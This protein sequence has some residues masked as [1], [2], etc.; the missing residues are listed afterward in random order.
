MLNGYMRRS[1]L[2][3]L[4]LLLS[5][6]LTLAQESKVRF[7]SLVLT[8]EKS[9]WRVDSP[10]G[11]DSRSLHHGDL[12]TTIDGTSAE[13]MGPLGVLAAV[14]ASMDVPVQLTVQRG[15]H[16][17]KVNLG[18]SHKPD[19][20][21]KI[22]A[23]QRYVTSSEKAPDFTLQTLN[24]VSTSLSAQRGKWV[25]IGF[26][27]TWCGPCQREEGVLEKL[28]RTYPQQLKVLALAVNDSSEKLNAFSAK[29]HPSYTILNA[30][31]IAGQPAISYGIAFPTGPALIP[32][33][34]LV[35]PDGSVAYAQAG[36][37]A[38][39]PLER[40]VVDLITA[41]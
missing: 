9:G 18:A 38:G 19:S 13:K 12:L 17:V 32:V 37:Y 16:S 8:Q 3:C 27:A 36:Y 7:S 21:W 41:R 14:I 20:A 28:A 34:V 25:L 6:N 23:T 22:G 5:F 1:V 11:A 10:S 39:S 40:E 26:W 4:C 15:I 29:F 31:R 24:N 2:S 33:T 35:R 30:G